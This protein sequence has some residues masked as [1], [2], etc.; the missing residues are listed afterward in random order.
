VSQNLALE[1][2]HE[3]R[4]GPQLDDRR[5]RA[6]AAALI[7]GFAI[8]AGPDDPVST[9]SGGNLQKLVLA[10]VLSRDPKAIV[11]S[12]PTRGLDVG[13]TEYVH[14]ELLAQRGRGAA[15][16]LVSED[17]DELL[18]LADRLLVL[19]EGRIVGELR[20]EDASPE[21]LGLLMAGLAEEGAAA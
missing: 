1:H 5:L 17:L 14:G 8:R 9:L 11:V 4:R 3:F 7:E 16:L 19:Y 12:Q 10:R 21:R 6:H 2:L 20:A 13:A 15:V 18:A